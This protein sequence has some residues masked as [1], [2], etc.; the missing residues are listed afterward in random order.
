MREPLPFLRGARAVSGVARFAL[1][2]FNRGLPGLFREVMNSLHGLTG[3]VLR[4]ADTK[5]MPIAWFQGFMP[6]EL[7]WALGVYP[8]IVEITPYI[9]SGLAEPLALEYLDAVERAG[10]PSHTC[11]AGRLPCGFVISGEMPRPD[12]I[13]NSAMPCD[14]YPTYYDEIERL[15][16]DVPLYR[17]DAPFLRDEEAEDYFLEEVLRAIEWMEGVT[18]NKL[19]VHKL[20]AVVEESNKAW[21][22]LA[23]LWEIL[24]KPPAVFPAQWLFFLLPGLVEKGHPRGVEIV[25]W[26]YGEARRCLA[27]GKAHLPEERFRYVLWGVPG[28]FPLPAFTWLE[29]RYGA[30]MVSSMLMEIGSGPVDTSSMDSMLRGLCRNCRNS[31][32]STQSFG[33]SERF[34][35]ELARNIKDYSANLVLHFDHQG[36]KNTLGI[37]SLFRGVTRDLGVPLGIVNMDA[38]DSRVVSL[39]GVQAQIETFM[40][41]LGES[42]ASDRELSLTA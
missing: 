36:C 6:S 37:T 13:V 22:Y 40:E 14:N 27:E 33:P 26:L 15:Y 3:D 30:V 39:E 16:P 42:G 34:T 24:K 9:A 19:T 18:G 21:E 2:P 23:A 11:S 1:K 31:M 29:E 28:I 10:I 20:R 17:A 35:D 8:M 38:F 25:K 32:M 7:G 5:D 41:T 12:F 4:H